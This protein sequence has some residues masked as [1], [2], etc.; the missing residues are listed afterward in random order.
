[1]STIDDE[2]WDKS[3]DVI[4]GCTPISE[5]CEHCWA[6]TYAKR[7]WGKRKFSDI[8]FHSERLELPFRWRKPRRIFVCS[9]GD[10]FHEKVSI[11]FIDRIAI[12]IGRCQQHTYYLLTKRP[13][14]ALD[15]YRR[16]FNNKGNAIN[17]F[18]SNVFLGVTVENQ[19]RANERIPLLL[20]IPAAYRFISIKPMLSS[21]DFMKIP[22]ARKLRDTNIDWLILGCETGP[23]HPRL[24]KI[25]DM[26]DVANQCKEAKVPLWVKAVPI[27]SKPCH[28]IGRFPKEL[29]SREWPKK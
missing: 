8:R 22:M 12:I 28:D 14:K 16:F 23:L 1:M 21:I 13:K 3:W 27:D 6:A 24:C 10:L 17:I 2:W 4:S 18:Q 7:F 20:Q 19:K 9:V 5:A 11:G 25:E 26:I 15:C 29:R